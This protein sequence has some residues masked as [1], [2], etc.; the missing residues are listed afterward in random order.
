V[1][2]F[3]VQSAGDTK[4]FGKQQEANSSCE[5]MVIWEVSM[6][7]ERVDVDYITK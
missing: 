4:D 1:K 7:M 6:G 2:Q 5:S 3:G